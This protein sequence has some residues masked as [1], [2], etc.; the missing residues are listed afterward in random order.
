M[1]I[2]KD[3]I[4]LGLSDKAAEELQ[5]KANRIARRAGHGVATSVIMGSDNRVLD[6]TRYG[7]RK[8]TTGEYVPNKYRANFGWKNTYYQ[9]AQTVVEVTDHV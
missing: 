4:D 3:I 9:S 2:C 1:Y 7:Y 5:R 8:H 6:H